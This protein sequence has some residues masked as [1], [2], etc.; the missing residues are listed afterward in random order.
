[1]MLKLYRI[2]RIEPIRS[3][4][5]GR[6]GTINCPMIIMEKLIRPTPRLKLVTQIHEVNQIKFDYKN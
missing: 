3:E 5:A 1:M 4:Y 6:V 2:P